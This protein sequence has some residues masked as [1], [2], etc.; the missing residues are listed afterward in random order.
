MN[1]KRTKSGVL[2]YDDF[3][4]NLIID[5]Y[6]Y[7]L[8]QMRGSKIECLRSENSEDAITWNVFR[9]L[10]Q[11]NPNMWLPLLFQ[12]SFKEEYSVGSKIIN[13]K[14]WKNIAP[15]TSLILFQK[16]EGH[17]EVDIII[18]SENFDWF[19]E[20]KYKS[21]ISMKTTNNDSR[22]QILRNIDVGTYYAGI[23]D[24]YFSLLYLEPKN[25]PKGI[26]TLNRYKNSKEEILQNLPHRNDGL[27]NLVTLGLLTWRDLKEVLLLCSDKSNRV[28]EKQYSNRAIQWLENK[29][30]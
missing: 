1:Y 29:K 5:R 15:P 21:D 25:S 13:I 23:K 27:K 2:V 22:D 17:S 30:I 12:R 19:I 6:D 28:D 3:R 18:E 8:S 4:D 7:T 26:E 11:I 9:T 24:F 10:N 20:A 14:L 16:D